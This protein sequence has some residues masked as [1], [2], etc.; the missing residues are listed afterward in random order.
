M[1]RIVFE[2]YREQV[3]KRMKDEQYLNILS[4]YTSSVF[5]DFESF[6]RTQIDLVEDDIKLVLAEYNSSFITYQVSPEIYTFKDIS[7]I[8]LNYVQSEYKG[9]INKIV[10]EFD[11]I[12]I[13]TKLV[14]KSG[15]I[16][17]R[18]EEKSFFSTILGFIS[19][20]DCKHY[21]EY[22]SQ[23]VLHL[24]STNIMHLKSDILDGSV[25]N[26]LR[27]PILFSFILD[28]LPGHKV[29]CAPESIHYKKINKSVLNT[30]TFSSEDDN[31]EE[32]NFNGET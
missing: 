12:T 24:G 1:G 8:L 11:D 6:L 31:N 23:K 28:K 16:A 22:I 2:E 21:N 20:W 30:K 10:I 25:V 19:G 7:E 15:I 27:Q 32:I 26:G 4:I 3:T 17:V 14:V 9:E 5:Q 13:K 29:F 18:F